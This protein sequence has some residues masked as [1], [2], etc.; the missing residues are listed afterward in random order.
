[1]KYVVWHEGWMKN[2]EWRKMKEERR[3][4]RRQEVYIKFLTKST[5]EWDMC[6]TCAFKRKNIRK[7]YN[8]KDIKGI[9][10]LQSINYNE[11]WKTENNWINENK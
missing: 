8:G 2:E 1:M 4:K 10:K 3:K 11:T 5:D 7:E 9:I 6:L